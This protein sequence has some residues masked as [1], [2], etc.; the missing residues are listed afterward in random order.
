MSDMIH[1]DVRRV[2]GRTE[3]PT[4]EPHF[5]P[6]TYTIQVLSSE[7]GAGGRELR[8]VLFRRT[9]SDESIEISAE[10]DAPNLLAKLP[11]LLDAALEIQRALWPA[12]RTVS[13]LSSSFFPL[14]AEESR[15]VRLLT[16]PDAQREPADLERRRVAREAMIV[17]D[18]AWEAIRHVLPP[19]RR[20]EID[21]L[22]KLHETPSDLVQSM[23][24]IA[25]LIERMLADPAEAAALALVDIDE[26]YAAALRRQAAALDAS[27]RDAV[28]TKREREPKRGVLRLI[29]MA[30]RALRTDAFLAVFDA[31]SP[32][33]TRGRA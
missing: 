3:T 7:P 2:D 30:Y 24:A 20:G 10:T 28:D 27:E 1:H 8:T 16:T 14:L 12:Q 5:G 4:N 23:N 31:A 6:V 25:G 18:V 33:R 11:D 9:S 26:L 22:V 15:L 19:E 21:S 32:P 17:R 29:G 13:K